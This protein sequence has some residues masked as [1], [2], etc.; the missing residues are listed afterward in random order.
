MPKDHYRIGLD[1]GGSKMLALVLDEAGAVLGRAKK[2]TRAEEGYA[3]VVE[4]MRRCCE[5]ALEAAGAQGW[6]H[7]EGIGVGVAGTVDPSKGRVDRAANLG[8]TGKRLGKDLSTA[9]G[10]VPVQLGNDVNCGALGEA[11]NG[12]GKG[13]SSVFAAF[14]GTGLGGGLVIKGH[15]V[16]GDHGYAGEFGHIRYP[17]NPNAQR[18]CGCGQLGCLE[19]V[20]SRRGIAHSL[21]EARAA[22]LTCLIPDSGEAPKSSE[23]AEAVEQGCPATI[24]ALGEAGRALG[25]GIGLAVAFVDPEIIV[26]GGGLAER[27]RKNLKSDIEAGMLEFGFFTDRFKAKIAYAGLGDDAVALGAAGLLDTTP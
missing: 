5:E 11:R 3:A 14:A 10:K 1:L 6:R 25:W 12:A 21:A 17:G 20:A 15:I 8:W 7:V 26:I 19:T 9:C 18:R 22:G 16:N 2:A 13:R 4:R 27:F 23:L 24:Q